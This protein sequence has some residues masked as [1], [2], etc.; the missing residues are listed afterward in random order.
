MGFTAQAARADDSSN[1]NLALHK[2]Y[3]VSD[4]N[5]YNFGI[6]GLTDGSWVANPVHCFATGDTDAFPKTATIDLVTPAKIGAVVLGVP[7]VG[8]TKTINVSVST[9]GKTFT[10]VGTYVFTQG[11]EE[12]HTYTFGTVDA[13]YVRLTYPDHYDAVVNYPNTFSFTEEC[14]VYA[15]PPADQ[16]TK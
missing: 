8:S 12:K 11:K 15:K 9:D 1:P 14:E 5:K 2:Q 6:G 3:E 16:A 7:A 13:R 4:P 10:Q